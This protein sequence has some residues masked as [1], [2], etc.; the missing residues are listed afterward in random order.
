LLTELFQAY[1]PVF[2]SLFIQGTATS[3]PRQINNLNSAIAMMW[4][5]Q[6]ASI[7]LDAT[8]IKVLENTTGLCPKGRTSVIKLEEH[9]AHTGLAH[10]PHWAQNNLQGMEFLLK[11][12]MT[13]RD[14]Q[15]RTIY[16]EHVHQEISSFCIHLFTWSGRRGVAGY[17]ES[18]ARECFPVC[19]R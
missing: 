14:M 2:S 10:L 12:P 6:H 5:E 15:G 7:L 18:N 8:M 4:T 11:S 9:Q 19:R 13:R 16:D 3:S 17:T 1:S